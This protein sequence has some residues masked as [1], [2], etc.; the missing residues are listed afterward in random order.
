MGVLILQPGLL[1]LDFK[2]MQSFDMKMS[3]EQ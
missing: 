3:G 2:Q 1:V